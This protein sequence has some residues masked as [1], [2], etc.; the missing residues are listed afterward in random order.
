MPT[1][2]LPSL[3]LPATGPHKP[4][5]GNPFILLLRFAEVQHA[6]LALLVAR[7]LVASS[8]PCSERA[9]KSERLPRAGE[10]HT[11][12]QLFRASLTTARSLYF[13]L[14]FIR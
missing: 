1:S 8:R 14:V 10:C 2:P 4:P 3:F 6:T 7:F 11:A 9:P 5:S 12:E 13:A